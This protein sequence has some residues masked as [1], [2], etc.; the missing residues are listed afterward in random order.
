LS[1]SLSFLAGGA[2]LFGLFSSY[3]CL[4]S[5]GP[6]TDPA[7]QGST[8]QPVAQN[9]DSF[10]AS[11]TRFGLILAKSEF[12]ENPEPATMVLMWPDA[13]GNEWSSETV[14]VPS[15]LIE[16]QL[17][18]RADGSLAYRKV[19]QEGAFDLKPI[20]GNWDLVAGATDGVTWR[21]KANG[22]P[23][24]KTYE[25]KGGNVFHKCMWW[26][27]EFGEPGILSISANMPFMLMWRKSGNSWTSELLWTSVVG[28]KEQR[29]RD[30]EIGDIDGDGHDELVLVTHDRAAVYVM[31]Q[32]AE[33][34]VATEIHRTVERLFVHEVEIGDVDGDGKLEFFTTPSE[35]NRSDGKPQLGWIDMYQYDAASG[36]YQRTVVD[37]LAYHAKEIM[38]ADYD[39]D[40]ISELYAAME[41]PEDSE[42]V[43]TIR[44][45][46]WVDGKMTATANIELNGHMCRFLNLA[47]TDGDDIN[48]IIASTNSAGVFK[49]WFGPV[50]PKAGEE[51]AE[52]KIEWQTKKIVPSYVSSSFE[53]ATAVFDW[54]GDGIDDIF[55]ASDNQ[56]V[57]NRLVYYPE[58][59]RYK[60]KKI[61]N[62]PD[63]SYL[64][65]GVMPLP[66][67]Q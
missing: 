27:P 40:G 23:D 1:K 10:S 62:W 61:A 16:V 3:S 30:V 5:E 28:G 32:T 51:D 39:G 26:D 64:T 59:N 45:Y 36:K 66:P 52:P 65:W 67:K 4:K 63:S 24:T 11:S 18:D 50:K 49:L 43:V 34:L 55:L 7:E 44:R 15:G 12:G 33:G 9:G 60:A 19:G 17:G 22:D 58:K 42:D 38:V 57:L 48:E 29:F 2:L 37:E 13:S 14:R 53:H 25:M 41:P 46:E 31:E 6:V 21:T 56:K 20:E 47:N 8:S 54:D 35:P